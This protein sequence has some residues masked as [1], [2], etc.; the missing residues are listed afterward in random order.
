MLLRII[1]K[2]ETLIYVRILN[3][4]FSAAIKRDRTQLSALASTIK[5]ACSDV[6]SPRTHDDR[7]VANNDAVIV[8]V[9]TNVFTGDG[10]TLLVLVEILSWP[11]TPFGGLGL[12]QNLAQTLGTKLRDFLKIFPDE[13]KFHVNVREF[14]LDKTAIVTR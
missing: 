2:E 5:F 13:R 6:I 1:S 7:Q 12:K 3:H 9:P 11:P 10:T 4:G 8:E 14:D